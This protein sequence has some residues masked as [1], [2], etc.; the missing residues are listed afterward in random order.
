MSE[1]VFF[2]WLLLQTAERGSMDMEVV[3]VW[4]S[5][6]GT[7]LHW[8]QERLMIMC[9]VSVR[10]SLQGC[11]RCTITMQPLYAFYLTAIIF[12]AANF[13]FFFPNRFSIKYSFPFP[14]FFWW[15]RG[16]FFFSTK[17]HCTLSLIS[18]FAILKS[19]NC[20]QWG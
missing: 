14:F 9:F 3:P 7:S 6:T 5:E 1:S 2:N 18:N 10:S 11:L 13:I 15:G 19:R 17:D 16:V 12:R 8:P 4:T 20:F